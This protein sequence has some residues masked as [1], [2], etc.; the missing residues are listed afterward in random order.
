MQTQCTLAV[1]IL[2]KNPPEAYR[3]Q[4]VPTTDKEKHKKL[5]KAEVVCKIM[6]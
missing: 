2:T 3:V 4:N 5:L 6:E 1:N